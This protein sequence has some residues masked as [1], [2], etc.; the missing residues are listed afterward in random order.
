MKIAII[1]DVHS[2][3]Y[4]M[5]TVVSYINNN[6]IEFTISVGDLL[7]YACYPEEVYKELIKLKHISIIGNHDAGVIGTTS[8]D[9]FN[10]AAKKAINWTKKRISKELKEYLSSLKYKEIYNEFTVVH[11]TFIY[12][13]KWHYLL[14]IRE[15][16]NQLRYLDTRI[17]IVGHSHIP[18]ILE[19]DKNNSIKKIESNE[20]ILKKDRRYIL[21]PGSVGQ[22]RDRDPRL[23][24]MI[25]N[26]D[27]HLLKLVRL[28]YPHEKMAE[29]IKKAGLPEFL[30][31]RLLYGT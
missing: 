26:E 23:S 19:I 25:F 2:N 10:Y 16:E 11:G 6:K 5:E 17:G 4:A 20:Y 27:T 13:E 15:A 30:G 31:N 3:L 21:N 1:S 22:P 18:F 24:F 12:P 28:K 9:L 7:G 29:D 8:I 14:N